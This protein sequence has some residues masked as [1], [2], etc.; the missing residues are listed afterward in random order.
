M[1]FNNSYC[2]LFVTLILIFLPL[3]KYYMTSLQI[4]HYFSF[5]EDNI[6]V[7][8]RKAQTSLYSL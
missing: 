5:E 2:Y 7:E 8:E 4:L 6:N 3:G 1:Q